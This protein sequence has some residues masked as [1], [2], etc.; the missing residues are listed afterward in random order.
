[1]KLRSSLFATFILICEAVGVALFLRG[2][3]PVPVKSSLSSKSRLSDLPAEPLTGE[4][5]S[6]DAASSPST[7]LFPNTEPKEKNNKTFNCVFQ[8]YRWDSK[9]YST[10]QAFI[11]TGGHHASGC[12][13]RGLCVW[14]QRSQVHALHQAPGGER[15][16]QQLCGQSETSHC[17]NAP[18]KGKIWQSFLCH[19]ALACSVSQ[20]AVE[21][22]SLLVIQ[23]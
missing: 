14:T 18:D 16:V 21:E 2:F 4:L 5:S 1:M 20:G 6:L 12:P 19:P 8:L 10:P 9:L 22:T 3:F 13:A 17:H 15:L 23:F 7:V 11:Q